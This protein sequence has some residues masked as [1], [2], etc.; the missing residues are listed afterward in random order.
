MDDNVIEQRLNNLDQRL[1]KIEQILPT[2]ATKDDLKAFATKDDLKAESDETRR[3]MR[4]LIEAQ[5]SKLEL[6]AEHVL[7][8]AAR[9]EK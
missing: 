8:L 9:L 6:I 1:E 3:Y 4:I 7:A 2:L 5:D